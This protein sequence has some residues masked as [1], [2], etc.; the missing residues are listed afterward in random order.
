MDV[1]AQLTDRFLLAAAARFEHYSDFGDAHIGKLASSYK[2]NDSLRLRGSVSGGFRVR[3]LFSS[4]TSAPP[5]RTSCRAHRS[6][7]W[8]RRTA[9]RLRW[10]RVS[11]CLREVIVANA[12]LGFAYAPSS[13]LSVTLDAYQV[14]VRDRIV[15]IQESTPAI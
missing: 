3:P 13:N 11:R 9:V 7:S 8:S 4:S 6:T 15:L 14:D 2:V 12:S 5:S 10:R 1:E